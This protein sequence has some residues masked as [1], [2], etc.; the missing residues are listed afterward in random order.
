MTV[1]LRQLF[2][3]PLFAVELLAVSLCIHILGLASSLYVMQVLNR[4]V[5]H[6]LDSTLVTLTSGAILAI[7]MEYGFRQARLKLTHGVTVKPDYQLGIGIFDRITTTSAG[8]I[9]RLNPA[10]QREIVAAPGVLGRAHAPANLVALIDLPFALMFVGVLFLIQPSVGFVSLFFLVLT[11]IV[12]IL[13]HPLLRGL[14]KEQSQTASEVSA[15]SGATLRAVDAV[16]A[17][18]GAELLKSRFRVRQAD[19]IRLQRLVETRR[20]LIQTAAQSLGALMSVFVIAEGARLAVAGQMDVGLLVSAN[21]LASR[22]MAPILRFAQLGAILG[23]ARRAMETLGSFTRLPVERPAGAQLKTFNGRLELKDLAFAHPDIDPLFESL[24]LTLTAGTS[25][26]VSGANG[27]GKTTLARILVGLLEP[28]RGQILV[29]GVNLD[30]LSLAWWRRQ[31][32]YL[33]Q[34]PTFIE[35][36]IRDNL[37]I[38]C[39]DWSEEGMNAAIAEAGLAKFLHDSPKGLN[40]PLVNG[41]AQLAMGIRKRLAL[42]RALGGACRLVIFD[43]PLEGMDL[44][45]RDAVTGVI[46]RL[47]KQGRGVI[48]FSHDA[49]LIRGADFVLNLDRKPVPEVRVKA[50]QPLEGGP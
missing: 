27:S 19:G 18:N 45:G 24:N 41:G 43:E 5:S 13:G 47:A 16:R 39:P 38:M 34:E 42:A 6:G 40:T 32:V 28:T 8:S 29:D 1:L 31:V 9:D 12:S 35:G 37:L 36:T 21:I 48:V 23:E 33:P 22:A 46:A 20:E 14:L 26:V 10:A 2:S 11:F 49:G 30:Q 50:V 44:P 25:L 17:F 15:L 7:L 4:Y 3:R